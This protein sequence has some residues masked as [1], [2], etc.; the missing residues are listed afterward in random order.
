MS[1]FSFMVVD[2]SLI[3]QRKL[4]QL[5][6]E[7][8]HSVA[9]TCVNGQQACEKYI[10]LKPDLVTMD[11]TM[12]VMD[13][14]EA[15]KKIIESDPEAVVVMVTSHGQKQTV[16]DAIGAG[17]KGYILKPFYRDNVAQTLNKVI[18]KYLNKE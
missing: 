4:S 8:G 10:Q 18:N 7:L 12:P 11:I 2:D 3:T 1:K 14:I 6:E 9:G 16:I 5:L 13:G 15:T 17:A